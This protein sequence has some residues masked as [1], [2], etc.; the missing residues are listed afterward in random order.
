[1]KS[2]IDN[3]WSNLP[4]LNHHSYCVEICGASRS[5]S[6][7]Q[8]NML[9]IKSHPEKHGLCLIFCDAEKTYIFRWILINVL[10]QGVL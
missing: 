1:M 10:S 7:C 6:N 5:D 3:S 2:F 9:N 4:K 8:I